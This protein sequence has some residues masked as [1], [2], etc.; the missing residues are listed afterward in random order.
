VKR[1]GWKEVVKKFEIS[2]KNFSSNP[3]RSIT[4]RRDSCYSW[5]SGK[6]FEIYKTAVVTTKILQDFRTA[7]RVLLLPYSINTQ[8]YWWWNASINYCC[9]YTRSIDYHRKSVDYWV[10]YVIFA[11]RWQ[12]SHADSFHSFFSFTYSVFQRSTN[13]DIHRTCH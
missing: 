8:K 7:A 11:Y 6:V 2:L 13:M 1:I 12:G 3:W 4:D 5:I 9:I 10:G